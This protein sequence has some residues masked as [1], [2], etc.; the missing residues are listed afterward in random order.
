MEENT[1]PS[2]A[3]FSIAREELDSVRCSLEDL[4]ED[5]DVGWQND[6]STSYPENKDDEIMDVGSEDQDDEWFPNEEDVDKCNDDNC[7]STDN[8]V[9]VLE[10]V[11]VYACVCVCVCVLVCFHACGVR[12]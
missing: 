1:P 11:C 5:I 6:M 12:M 8:E 4:M 7:G 3:P 2:K 9:C 10:Y